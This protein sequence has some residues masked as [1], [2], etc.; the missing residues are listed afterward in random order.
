MISLD[1]FMNENRNYTGWG[2]MRYSIF[3]PRLL[4]QL[5]WCAINR[6]LMTYGDV[7]RNVSFPINYQQ[8]RA[9]GTAAGWLAGYMGDYCAA[10]E[11]PPLNALI[12]NEQTRIPS[13]GATPYFR[14]YGIRDYEQLDLE[15]KRDALENKLYPLIFQGGIWSALLEVNDIDLVRPKRFRDYDQD[16]DGELEGFQLPRVIRQGSVGESDAHK[17]L[18]EYVINNCETI[19][20]LRLLGC[21][22]DC[23]ETEHLLP[24]LDRPDVLF[25]N[26]GFSV[27]CEIK[28]WHSDED[29]LLRGIFQCVKYTALLNAIHT[30]KGETTA[31]ECILIVQEDLPRELQ[32]VANRLRVPHIRLSRKKVGN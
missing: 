29:D 3:A 4:P 9:M 7:A 5:L 6:K 8:G 20:N 24:S 18:K 21:K 25:R 16:E 15:E 23:A 31:S 2:K 27:A 13:G 26:D 12:V 30:L 28:S 32:R 10:N 17:A 19:E 11:L 14:R 1:E 22:K